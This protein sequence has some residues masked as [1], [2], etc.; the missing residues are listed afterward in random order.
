M[1]IALGSTRA[2]AAV[3]R[4][5]QL[6][7]EED[8]TLDGLGPDVYVLNVSFLNK[9][10]QAMRLEPFVMVEVQ[11]G[12]GVQADQYDVVIKPSLR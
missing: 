2:Q 11:T 4:S 6:A 8:A 10:R 1:R 5:F 7:P 3:L 9:T 12:R